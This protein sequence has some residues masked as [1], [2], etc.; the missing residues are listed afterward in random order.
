VTGIGRSRLVAMIVAVAMIAVAVAGVRLSEAGDKAQLIRGGSGQVLAIRGGTVH[1]V[2]VRV[3]TAV[4][5]FGRTEP[6]NGLFV[7][8]RVALAATGPAKLSLM[9]SKLLAAPDRTYTNFGSTSGVTAE[10]GFET[11]TELTFEVDPAHLDNLTLTLSPLE[12]VSG[13]QQQVQIHLG[14]TPDNAAD[15]RAAAQGQVIAV[16]LPANRGI[17]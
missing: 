14:I 16:A 17:A 13:Y 15:W 5:N 7:V 3:G 6:T 2:E 1:A 4:K 10:P 8:V 9:S 12:I 11:T